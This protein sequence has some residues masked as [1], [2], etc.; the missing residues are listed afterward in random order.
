MDRK[1]FFLGIACIA[2]AMFIFAVTKPATKPA[3][4]PAAVV[5]SA[6]AEVAAVVPVKSSSSSV[7]E[8]AVSDAEKVVL[9]NGV[10]RVTFSTRGG[11]IEQVELLRQ[12]A[13]LER[14]A[15]IIFNAGNADAA[16]AIGILNSST[17]RVE[18]VYSEFKQVNLPASATPAI[19]FQGKL[20]DG[21][22]VL[23]TYTLSAADKEGAEP[24]SIRF[25]TKVIPGSAGQMPTRVW[26]STG[27][28]QHTQG[29]AN[30]QFIS[31]LADNGEDLTHVNIGVFKDSSGFFGLGSHK[32]EAEHPAGAVG[33]P[34][35]WVSSGNQFF[36]SIIH[37][38]AKSRGSR[39]ELVARPVAFSATDVGV[40]AFAYWE[41]AIGADTSI[42]TEGDFFVGP[43]EYARVAA[44]PDNQV[45][46][47][48]FSKILGFIS[49]GAICKLLLACLGGVHSLLTWTGAW[50][51]GWA[52]VLL[53]VLIKLITW[54]LTSA[55]QRTA[56]KMQQFSGPMAEIRE[57]Y[58][59]DSEKLNKEMMKLYQEHQINPFAGCLPILIQIPVFFGL[60]TAF[61]TTVELRLQSFLW[62]NDLAAP[63]TL[64]HVA[65]FGINLLPILMGITMWL[66]MRMTPTP[67]ADDT[68]KTIMYMMAFL[69]PV[70]CYSLP[71]ALSL[72]MT[73]QNLLTMLQAWRSNR[74]PVEAVVVLPKKK[75]SN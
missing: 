57:K 31:V 10:V 51:W 34:F 6:P 48:Q 61:Q 73:L 36:A 18:P 46:V 75:K 43:K 63:D 21:T 27:S 66:S 42:V 35:N 65:G 56:K 47:L 50:S 25:T 32:A 4:A 30:H 23:R 39:S 59:N 38:D 45:S 64:F 8:L 20:P 74:A 29:D 22:K 11:A 60:Y 69:F 14:K 44:L 71:A 13:N 37:V 72:Y 58:K 2:A 67:S 12:S 5:A 70:I 3:N 26:H 68:Q 16:M 9:E 52:V 33:Q 62:I 24:Y 49:F 1:N 7:R 15:N 28:W 17:N 54:P 55:Q 19:A 40:Q 41:G 53:T